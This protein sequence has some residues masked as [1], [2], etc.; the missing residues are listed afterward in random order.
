MKMYVDT[1]S[2]GFN[3]T[4][5]YIT[6]MAGTTSH[7]GLTSYGAIYSPSNVGFVVYVRSVFAWTGT[8]MVTYANNYQWNLNWFGAVY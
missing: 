3:S 7:F 2:C 5:V 8:D 1:T 4:P 6:S